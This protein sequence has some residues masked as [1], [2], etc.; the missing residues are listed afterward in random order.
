MTIDLNTPVAAAMGVFAFLGR[1]LSWISDDE[2]LVY[3][4]PERRTQCTTAARFSRPRRRVMPRSGHCQP[5]GRSGVGCDANLVCKRRWQLRRYDRDQKKQGSL[6]PS[7]DRLFPSAACPVPFKIVE[8]WL[9]VQIDLLSQFRECAE[10]R[11][12][13]VGGLH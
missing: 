11:K 6:D 7:R 9:K 4:R 2:P 8:K 3:P 1:L 13:D 12:V 10:V 5:A